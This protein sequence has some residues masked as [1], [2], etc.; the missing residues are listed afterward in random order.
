MRKAASSCRHD[1]FC[2][3]GGKHSPPAVAPE[4]APEMGDLAGRLRLAAGLATVLM[5]LVVCLHAAKDGFTVAAAAIVVAMGLG[6]LALVKIRDNRRLVMAGSLYLMGA[7]A[8]IAGVEF[9]TARTYSGAHAVSWNAIWVAF[10]PMLVPCAPRHTLVKGVIAATLTPLVFI[11]VASLRAVPVPDALGLVQLFAPVYLAA[12]LGYLSGRYLNRLG[13]D[14][15][16]ARRM[17]VYELEEQLANGGMGEVWRAQHKLLARPAAIKLV[18]PVTAAGDSQLDIISRKRFEREAQ[19][20]ASLESPHTVQLYDFGV[21]RDGVF[22]YVME[23][24]EGM[25]LHQLV[26]RHGP[27]P[28]ERVKHIMLQALESLAEAHERGLVHRDIKPANLFIGKRGIREDFVRVLDFGLVRG[29]DSPAGRQDVALTGDHE[30]SGTPAFMAPEMIKGGPIDGRADLYA[31]A[32]VAYWLLTGSYVF[33]AESVMEMAIAHA[34]ENPMPPSRRAGVR[35]PADF[36]AVLMRCLEKEPDDRPA[37]ARELLD[38]L[39]ACGVDD[40]R[41]DMAR[42]WWRDT[43]EMPVTTDVDLL[44]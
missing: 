33:D 17:G 25:D 13:E 20:T 12:G 11:V 38:L 27:M 9:L 30:V 39:D 3:Q 8:A 41:P 43:G 22:Y 7:S 19:V 36:E 1:M 21:T 14:I 6:W 5:G 42:R 2:R 18:K 15:R 26:R 29:A 40:W 24:L 10:F 23:L 34:T 4:V 16:Q 32:C 44:M 31:L 35:V 28:P 37:N